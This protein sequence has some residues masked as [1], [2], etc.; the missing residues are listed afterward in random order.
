[1]AISIL[2]LIFVFVFSFAILIPEGKEYRKQ[3]N[4]L[5]KERIE[6]MR[7]ENFNSDTLAVLKNLQSKHRH[8]ILAFENSF[9]PKKFEQK[10]KKY[11]SELVISKSQNPTKQDTFNVY[12]VNTTSKMDSPRGFYDFLDSINKSDWIIEVN[13]PI[14]FKRE[15][16]LIKSSFSMK[17]YKIEKNKALK[18]VDK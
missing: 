13:F 11:F 10:H 7:F 12:D 5:K 2:L 3:R 15:N 18:L 9:N 17:V 8:T 6:L 1:M 16:N 14:N 4:E